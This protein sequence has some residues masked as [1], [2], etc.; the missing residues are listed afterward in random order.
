M[1]FADPCQ[2]RRERKGLYHS[3]EMS[4]RMEPMNC[5][6]FSCAVCYQSFCLINKIW[7]STCALNTERAGG[8]APWATVGK[9]WRLWHVSKTF[10]AQASVS[11]F[12]LWFS[13]QNFPCTERDSRL[14]LVPSI[15]CMS[16]LYTF[17]LCKKLAVNV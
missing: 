6:S 5:K 7:Y 9:D 12:V 4:R 3:N 10:V 17:F 15:R 1:H 13:C 16:I 8:F 11:S 14:G 2:K